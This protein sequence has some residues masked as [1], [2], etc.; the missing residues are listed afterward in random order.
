MFYVMD[1]GGPGVT[2]LSL[3][4]L[5]LV[6]IP[7]E[8]FFALLFPEAPLIKQVEGSCLDKPYYIL[9]YFLCLLISHIRPKIT[10][11]GI[12]T[13]AV[14]LIPI[15]IKSLPVSTSFTVPTKRRVGPIKN[16]PGSERCCLKAANARAVTSAY[17]GG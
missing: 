11:I 10:R 1:R 8:Y 3:A 2:P 13:Y 15:S 7:A 5:A 14:S 6:V 12:V 9:G 4:G 16:R 17:K